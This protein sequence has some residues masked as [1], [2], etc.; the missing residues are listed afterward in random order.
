M[1]LEKTTVQLQFQGFNKLP[2]NEH[3]KKFKTSESCLDFRE[4]ADV[5][6]EQ[7]GSSKQNQWQGNESARSSHAPTFVLFLP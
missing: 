1:L 7:L 4:N 2:P 3:Q 6:V 5:S